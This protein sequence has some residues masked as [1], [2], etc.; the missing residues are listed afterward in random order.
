M[1]FV[2]PKVH[3]LTYR[4]LEVGHRC[5]QRHAQTYMIEEQPHDQ[6][7]ESFRKDSIISG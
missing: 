6:P 2:A 3:A 7:L 4:T 5:R 1:I